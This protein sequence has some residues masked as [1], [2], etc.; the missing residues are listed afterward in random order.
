MY[1][2]IKKGIASVL[3]DPNKKKKTQIIREFIL[4]WIS[5]KKIPLHYFSRFLY[6]KEIVNYKNY[7]STSQ[8]YKLIYSDKVQ[9]EFFV[10]ILENKLLFSFFCKNN[11]LPIPKL[12]SFNSGKH[13]YWNQKSKTINST[14]ELVDFFNNIFSTS[15]ISNIFIKRQKNKGGTGIF[16]LEKDDLEEQ[17]KKIGPD[18]LS[19]S[20]IHQKTLMQHEKVNEIY[21]KSINSIRFDTCQDK[22]NKPQLLGAVM[23]F[24]CGGNFID[25]RSKGGFFVSIDD[26]S[27]CLLEKGYGQMGFGGMELS[28]H[29]DTQ[30]IFKGFRIPFYEESKQL[31]LEA[32]NVISNKII[33]WDI[34]ITPNGPII[35]EGNHDSNITMTEKNNRGYLD[36]PL[37]KMLIESSNN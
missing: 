34:A 9:N 37:I 5:N 27:G 19:G 36:H 25:N 29:P 8:Y 21:E 20:F 1:Y 13:F 3:S 16:Y 22:N 33:G 28:K 15:N 6:R 26:A 18:L 7:I 24:G 31:A 17:I 11:V 14:S 10:N 30:F 32:S 12:I 4:L 35:I 23:R 2:K